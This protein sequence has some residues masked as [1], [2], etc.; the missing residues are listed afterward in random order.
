MKRI[1]KFEIDVF[2]HGVELYIGLP[3]EAQTTTEAYCEP[4]KPD[5]D[6]IYK[7]GDNAE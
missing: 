4:V 3:P 5:D 1:G 7:G 6:I 2:K